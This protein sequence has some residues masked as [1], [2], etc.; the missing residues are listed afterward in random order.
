M[1]RHRLLSLVT[2][3]AILAVLAPWAVA[4][5]SISRSGDVGPGDPNTWTYETD[6]YVGNTDDGVLIADGCSL[7][8]RDCCLGCD[9][10]ATGQVML[11]G[12]SWYG[13]GD[14]DVGQQGMGI[15][16]IR[17]GV[18]WAENVSINSQSFVSI[19]VDGI[20]Q[21]AADRDAGVI[22]NDGVIRIM[23]GAR[24]WPGQ[25]FEP[26]R[27]VEYEGNG[28]Y[29]TIGGTW[30]DVCHEFTAS[31][32]LHAGA[33]STL[34]FDLTSIQRVVYDSQLDGQKLGV[35]FCAADHSTPVE[36]EA[37]VCV[38]EFCPEM[39]AKL[40]SLSEETEFAGMWDFRA[41]GSCTSDGPA[42]LTFF[43]D[44]DKFF[45][46]PQVWYS[47]GTECIA[48]TPDDLTCDG[49][50]VNFSV[51]DFDGVW[52]V[53]A[54]ENDSPIPGDADISGAV[55]AIDAHIL[56][57]NW[58]ST[59]ATWFEGDFSGD[60]VVDHMDGA[61][62]AASWCGPVGDEYGGAVPEPATL[63]LLLAAALPMSLR[64]KR[65]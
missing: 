39:A 54:S 20:G 37:S 29:Q 34:N 17:R 38:D 25:R 61:I 64:R 65:R 63:V 23:A 7:R 35:S 36:F 16:S 53:T 30:S 45:E 41:S 44:S 21:L 33:G 2:L 19:A 58:G 43:C 27:A 51:D 46:D 11:R 31:P 40:Y 5:A 22:T 62:M 13:R 48:Y 10:G 12:S 3:L 14:I 24:P 47:D 32:V 1:K 28:V 60:G 8:T 15:L 9:S 55:N 18:V 6:A 42:Y 26:L 56:A 52:L 4:H 49:K 50:Y 59:H 57:A